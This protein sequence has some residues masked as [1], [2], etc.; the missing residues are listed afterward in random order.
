MLAL[1]RWG[2]GFSRKTQLLL[3]RHCRWGAV[4]LNR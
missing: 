2:S 4:W 1:W 3:A